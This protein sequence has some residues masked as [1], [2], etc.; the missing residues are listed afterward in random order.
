MLSNV[1][2]FLAFYVA[3]IGARSVIRHPGEA[4][5]DFRRITGLLETITV[6]PAWKLDYSAGAV[7]SCEVRNDKGCKGCGVGR[8]GER[9]ADLNY[10]GQLIIKVLQLRTQ[11]VVQALGYT[12]KCS[13]GRHRLNLH[14]IQSWKT[15][16]IG[17][18]NGR[19]CFHALP[20]AV[21]HLSLTRLHRS[22]SLARSDFVIDSFVIT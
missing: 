16:A 15:R 7:A 21:R 14:A 10:I 12:P 4:P 19:S 1:R 2:V 3:S 20:S 18:L 22:S 8:R 13:Q 11:G 17:E 6:L 9:F 5:E